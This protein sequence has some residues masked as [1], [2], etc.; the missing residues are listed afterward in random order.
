MNSPLQEEELEEEDSFDKDREEIETRLHIHEDQVRKEK[1]TLEA[2]LRRE[3]TTVEEA[4]AGHA[5]LRAV[6]DRVAKDK[7]A[8]EER[9]RAFDQALQSIQDRRNEIHQEYRRFLDEAHRQEQDTGATSFCFVGSERSHCESVIGAMTNCGF[10]GAGCRGRVQARSSRVSRS[11]LVHRA[12]GRWATLQPR[13]PGL[14]DEPHFS[15][16][17]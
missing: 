6:E 16:C 13:G 10:V 2:L 4:E 14:V 12:A 5:S 9:R 15:A 17:P 7:S 8:L 11:G 3:A 1:R